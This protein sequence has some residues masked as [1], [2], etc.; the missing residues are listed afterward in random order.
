MSSPYLE[1]TYRH[2]RTLAA[3]L[4]LERRPGD[5]A[6]ST[7]AAGNGIVVDFASDGRP[8]GVEITS[9]RSFD[10]R[11]LNRILAELHIAPV[12]LEDLAPLGTP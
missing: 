2:G 4:H 1:V 3:Y 12:P 5:G 10:A 9:P 8:I 7:R 6:A 11:D